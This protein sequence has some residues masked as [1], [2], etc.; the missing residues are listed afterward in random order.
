MVVDSPSY[1]ALVTEKL[2]IAIGSVGTERFDSIHFVAPG[3][4]D[5]ILDP[6]TTIVESTNLDV[7]PSSVF[8]TLHTVAESSAGGAVRQGYGVESY[9]E[10]VLSEEAIRQSR[11]YKP[12][13]VI[14]TAVDR[15]SGSSAAIDSKEIPPGPDNTIE[16]CIFAGPKMD[17]QKQ[18]WS[19][20]SRHL[21]H[22]GFHFTWLVYLQPNVTLEDQAASNPV[23]QH[24]L[25]LLPTI[26][27]S[28]NPAIQLDL[29]MLNEDPGDGR[30]PAALIWR[31]AVADLYMYAHDSLIAAEYVVDRVQPSWCRV[32]F[33]QARRTLL[34]HRCD[35]AVYGNQGGFGS[36]VGLIHTARALGIP[37]V[38]EMMNLH[39]HPR[40]V[41]A[42]VVAPST[43]VLEHTDIA[44]VLEQD[45][46]TGTAAA[47]GK[48][49]KGVVIPPSIDSALFDPA[50]FRRPEGKHREDP[51]SV[52]VYAH[53]GCRGG[54]LPCIVV[55]F[56]A[57]LS[58]GKYAYPFCSVRSQTD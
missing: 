13:D 24:L 14:F 9:L 19:Q 10:F 33:E 16:V 34:E 5:T 47:T 35:I 49:V 32:L 12:R 40:M 54:S 1:G 48:Q 36:D 26:T 2:E 51:G 28:P 17:G 50:R 38:A 11:K 15:P 6:D 52:G 23:V 53:P 18:I 45:L 44:A 55:G 29:S 42:A 22:R 4:A 39:L 8:Y 56:V 30:G 58:P 37:T 27:V 20:Q 41:P 46:I 43:F 31:G 3:V 7:Q 57:R 21:S 25:T